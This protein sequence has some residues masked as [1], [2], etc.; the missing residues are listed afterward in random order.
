MLK[1]VQEGGHNIPYEIIE[2][3]YYRGIFNLMNLYIQICDNWMVVDNMDLHPQEVALGGDTGPR[4]II[5]SYIWDTIL[6]QSKRHE[7]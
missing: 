1:R 7:Q 6:Q 2:R 5:K 4:L 3:R